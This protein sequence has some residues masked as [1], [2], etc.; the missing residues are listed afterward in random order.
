MPQTGVHQAK[1]NREL[2]A[3]KK[4]GA[5]GVAK[6]PRSILRPMPSKGGSAIT[7][8]QVKASCVA[9]AGQE[10]LDSFVKKVCNDTVF[11][12]KWDF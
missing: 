8:E 6:K 7:E 1:V 9:K 12:K 3:S 4:R 11:Y 5:N 2:K 10:L